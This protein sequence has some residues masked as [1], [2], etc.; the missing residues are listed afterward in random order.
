MSKNA[1][2]KRAREKRREL[3]PERCL[4]AA[5]KLVEILAP[6]LQGVTLSFASFGDEIDL[7]LLNELLL[8]KKYLLLPGR[9]HERPSAFFVQDFSTQLEK[10]KKGYLVPKEELC[11]QC[12]LADI[13]FVLVPALAFDE[14]GNRIGYGGG[15][16]D[17]LLA[18]LSHARKIGVGF[19]EQ[20]FSEDLPQPHDMT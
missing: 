15:F 20:L 4:P 11:Q 12:P 16:Y 6:R 8:Q 17:R 14:K 2:R 10:S 13:A 5:G 1:L 19:I 18:D 3:P 7:G 9:D